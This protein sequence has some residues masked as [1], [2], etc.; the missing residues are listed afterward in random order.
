MT[1]IEWIDFLVEI[2]FPL[3]KDG[4][5]RA[6]CEFYLNAVYNQMVTL[7][8]YD[9]EYDIFQHT[10]EYTSQTVTEDT[11]KNQFYS[12]LPCVL[13]PIK[14]RPS[15]I[16]KINTNQG[17]DADFVPLDEIT[18]GYF[19][20]LEG[21]VDT[22]IGYRVVNDKIWY[23]NFMSDDIAGAGVRMV[24]VPQFRSFSRT[25]IITAPNGKD[26]DLINGAAALLQTKKPVDNRIN[27]IQN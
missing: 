3:K 13:V 21:D 15:G 1:K 7:A 2:Q 14:D 6:L 20:G 11:T 17:Y 26:A 19:E 5:A 8:S 22:S 18:M 10:K 25:D 9:P 16:L 23:D 27:N 12:T 4:R 24:V